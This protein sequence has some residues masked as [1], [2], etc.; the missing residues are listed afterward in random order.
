MRAPMALLAEQ[1]LPQ[2]AARSERTI[3]FAVLTF[4][5]VGS[6]VVLRPFFSALLWAIV[7]SFSLWPIKR[8]LTRAFGGRRSLAALVITLTIAAALFVP[9]VVAVTNLAEDARSLAAV[10][11][12]WIQSGPPPAP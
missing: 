6:F 12:G 1:K 9:L 11:K 3:G 5:L 7:L 4:L 8:R 10:G 2:R